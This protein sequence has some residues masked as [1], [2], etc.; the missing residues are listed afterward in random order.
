MSDGT[1]AHTSLISPAS[2]SSQV[3][4][5]FIFLAT[6]PRSPGYCTHLNFFSLQQHC[7]DNSHF[8]EEKKGTKPL[9]CCVFHSSL[10]FFQMVV[11]AAVC[12]LTWKQCTTAAAPPPPPSNV[13]HNMICTSSFFSSH[14]APLLL[15]LYLDFI[16]K[17]LIW[18]QFQSAPEPLL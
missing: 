2:S 7:D 1:R 16:L 15:S 9:N 4:F 13:T 17:I 12:P 10:I 11:F 5:C 14:S 3:M 18:L 8:Q 6:L